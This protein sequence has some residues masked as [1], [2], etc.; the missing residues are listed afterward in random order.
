MKLSHLDR[1]SHNSMVVGAVA[2]QVVWLCCCWHL[3]AA[4]DNLEFCQVIYCLKL[5]WVRK[6]FTI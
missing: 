5:K 3:V 6:G 4:Q 2:G 1:P